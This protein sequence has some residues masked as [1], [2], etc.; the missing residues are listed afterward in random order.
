MLL[1]QDVNIGE[2]LVKRGFALYIEENK[3]TE[4]YVNGDSTDSH[5][6]VNGTNTE[7]TNNL[8]YRPAGDSDSE[9]ESDG[10]EFSQWRVNLKEKSK[11]K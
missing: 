6:Y 9:V 7:P 5:K 8:R 1:F 4:K 3:D 11:Q 2:Q 10:L